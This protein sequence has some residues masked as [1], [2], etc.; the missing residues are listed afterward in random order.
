MEAILEHLSKKAKKSICHY[1]IAAI[2]LNKR[3]EVL[4]TCFNRPRFTKYGGG[5][6]AEQALIHKYY[7]KGL[8]TIYIYRVTK[9][10]DRPAPIDPCEVC[11]KIAKKLGIKIISIRSGGK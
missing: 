2:G 6:H 1:K 7:K 9:G 11:L 5:I 8:K 3:G 10:S 4:G